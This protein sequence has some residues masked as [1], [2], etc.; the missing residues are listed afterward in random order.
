MTKIAIM[1]PYFCPY[2]GY[3][4]LIRAADVF[5]IYD[6]IEYTKKGWINRNRFLARGEAATFSI[7][8]KKDSD[9]L[10]VRERFVADDF[11][12]QKLL[13]QMRGA[14]GKA[15]FFAETFPLLERLVLNQER[16]LFAF[17]HHSVAEI[18]E[19]LEIGTRIVRSSDVQIDH[20]LTSQDK[21]VAICQ[22]LEAETYVNPIGGQELYAK[23][24]F[25]EQGLEL[26]FLQ[27]GEIVYPQFDDDF[28]AF[29]SIVDVM[30]F[31]DRKTIT[32]DFLQRY[33]LQ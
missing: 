12:P 8:I 3:F 16:N 17:I 19:A 11:K 13:N 25:R 31:N 15:P 28:V 30:M 23:D 2:I 7:P 24:A 18:C 6:N 4:Q 1:Q 32:E 21:V 33:Q 29:L 10:D 27:S 22:A 5:V 26:R 20:S 14:Y 9:H